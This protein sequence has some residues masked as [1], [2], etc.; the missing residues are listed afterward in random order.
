[1]VWKEMS[2]VQFI[3]CKMLMFQPVLLLL[4]AGIVP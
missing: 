1:M 3:L 4:E 2:N